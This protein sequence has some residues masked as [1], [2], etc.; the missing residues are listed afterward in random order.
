ML[1]FK[2]EEALDRGDIAIVPIPSAIGTIYDWK[3]LF[4]KEKMRNDTAFPGVKWKVRQIL[5][6]THLVTECVLGPRRNGVE[7]PQL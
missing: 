3:S 2:I 4:T 7:F 5:L 6:S 1:H